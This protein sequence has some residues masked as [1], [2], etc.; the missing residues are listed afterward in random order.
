MHGSVIREF[1]YCIK[2]KFLIMEAT[3]L[4]CLRIWCKLTTSVKYIYTTCNYILYSS[5]LL[6][7]YESN[8]GS[9]FV[10]NSKMMRVFFYEM[11][12]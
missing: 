12:E 9:N 11:R 2:E 1:I 8:A 10:G 3:K 7:N 6:Q 4:H 5:T